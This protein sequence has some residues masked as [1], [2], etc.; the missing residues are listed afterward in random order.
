M[1]TNPRPN[2]FLLLELDPG[3]DD[4]PTIQKRLVDKQRAWSTDK[5]MGNP[6][7]RR[8]AESSLALLQEI[9]AVLKDADARKREAGEARRQQEAAAKERLRDLDEAIALLK[10]G[11]PCTEEQIQKLVKQSNGTVTADEVRKRLQNA[12]VPLAGAGGQERRSRVP[13]AQIDKVTAGKIQ[14]NLEH[15][16][17]R[18]LYDF[19]ERRPQSSSKALADRAEEIYKEN[20]RLGR[21]DATASAQNELAGISKSVF[22]DDA[23]RAKYDNY[24]AVREMD[25]LKD[26]LELAGGDNFLAREE[27]DVLIHQAR[28]RGVTAEDARAY[29]EEYAALRKWGIQRDTSDL[30][31]ET[32]KLCGACGSLAPPTA[33]NC[34]RCGAAL[35]IECPR[36][37]ARSSNADAA[38]QSCGCHTGDAALVNALLREGERLILDGNAAA[39]LRCFDKALLYWPGWKPALDARRR[40][41]TRHQE[42][43]SELAALETLVRG[44]RLTGARSALERFE[45]S[46]GPA[47]L[48]GLKRKIQ[49]G[50]ARAEAAF[51]QGEARR[52]A[53]DGEKAL[54]HYEEALAACSDFEPAQRALT[55]SPP[56][57]PS[58]LQALPQGT[59]FRLSWSAATTGRSVLYRVLRKAGGMPLSPGDGEAL[60]ETRG[61]FLD[62]TAATP[63]TPWYYAVFSLRGGVSCQAP[64][65]TGPHLRT[66]EVEGLEVF[67]E[68]GGVILCWTAPTGCRRVEVW[69]RQGKPPSHPGEGTPVPVAGSDA[70]D[71]G[72]GNGQVYGYLIVAVFDDPVRPGGERFSAGRT[73]TAI[74]VAP[75]AAVMDLRASRNGNSVLLSW[76]PVPGT[77]VQIRQASRLAD[78]T[79]GLVL[80]VSQA[81]R[82]GA[83]VSGASSNAAQV[84]LTSQGQTF[85]VPLS[86]TSGTAVA[87]RA[88]TVTTLDPVS[89]LKAQ[90]AGAGLVLTW[91]WPQGSDEAL[92]AWTYE[93]CP[94]DPL[95]SEG[96]RIRVTRR[97][98]E[99]ASCWLLPHV[100]RR[101]H[102]FSVFT[103]APE[104]DLYSSPAQIVETLGQ[105]IT[106]SYQVVV[107]KALLR[108][109]VQDAWIELTCS[110]GG[111]TLPPLLVV[112]KPQSVPLSPRDGQLLTEAPAVCFE[113]G[114]ATLSIPSTCWPA[115][116]YVRLFFKNSEDAR[117]IRLLPAGQE[118][119]R[120]A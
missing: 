12:G 30:P 27:V 70:H 64:A 47:G 110:S 90:R 14:Q 23:E 94:E 22:R 66:A 35:E 55:A 96:G 51:T 45:R 43:E 99:R 61:T 74:P 84:S 62:D 106:V 38:C 103:K 46:H 4:W 101:P 114:K 28:Q 88:A 81:D 71:T 72:L 91:D 17:L 75:P 44:A 16:G 53:G 109:S 85:F 24:L 37:G 11:G 40:A 2:F 9:E 34:P 68:S 13:K 108:R 54:D 3:V 57:P 79:P 105:G 83:L 104:M 60:G 32:L 31:S 98:Y 25:G 26:R 33:S 111:T 20:Q 21:T 107:K 87:G 102:Y 113:R 112:G 1:S 48:D 19:L 67:A 36:C 15:L 69:R 7:A 89:G 49:D 120:I 8:R 92:V 6:K 63:G 118:R 65:G 78:Y 50:M 41:E 80:P 5:S 73:A 58:K 97:E 115:Q 52:R 100:E 42:R 76:T 82:F 39:A 86:V 56:P 77:L 95:E 117:E 119:L 29:I 116:P 93:R 10:T 18:T 59:G